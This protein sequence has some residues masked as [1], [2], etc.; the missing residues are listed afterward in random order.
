M[1]A[2]VQ[3]RDQH[4]DLKVKPLTSVPWKERPSAVRRELNVEISPRYAPDQRLENGEPILEPG[5]TWCNIYV[6]DYLRL[7]GLPAPTH[8][9]MADGSPASVGKGREL[10]ANGLVDWFEQYGGRYGW[11]KADSRVAQDAADRGH[12]VVVGWKN[13][14][15]PRPGHV[16]ILLG[17]DRIT[18][19]GAKNY[20]EATVKMGFG[21]SVDDK[22]LKWYVQMDRPGGHRG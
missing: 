19:A 22:D 11:A 2:P 8:W 17:R 9:V 1:G 16:A 13:P 5:T 3:T 4:L 15:P 20:F 7:M 12:V 10:R 14:H 21:R 18:Q 6:P